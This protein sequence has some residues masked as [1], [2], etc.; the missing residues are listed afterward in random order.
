MAEVTLE[1]DGREVSAEEEMTILEV[2]QG[3]G[4]EIPTLCYHPI[5][6]PYGA[7][8]LCIVEIEQRGRTRVVT[9]CNYPVKPGLKVK[10][11]SQRIVK[12]RRV[13]IELLLAQAP[14]VKVIQGLARKYN[15]EKIRFEPE[16]EEPC[17]L[18]GLCTR[19]CEE[20]VGASAINFAKRGIDREVAVLPEITAEACIGCG[21][22]AYICP[23]QAIKFEDVGDTRIITMPG[24]KLEFKLKKCQT[25]GYYWAPEKQLDYITKKLDLSPEIFDSCPNCRA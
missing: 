24:G 7:C 14:G 4:I 20:I 6:K 18:C 11:M 23:T 19:V 21:S 22:C 12:E 16:P 13:L 10:T 17:I 25:C 8:R 1:I 15:V 9:S 2:A 5:L 3:M